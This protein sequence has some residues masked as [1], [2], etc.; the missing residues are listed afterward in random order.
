MAPELLMGGSLK[1]PSDI[2]S[3]G[4]TV[5]EVGNIICQGS[6]N[7]HDLRIR[8]IRATLRS[9]IVTLEKFASSFF[10]TMSDLIDRNST[11][12]HS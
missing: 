5:Y 6:S 1:K 12:L 11:K 10:S 8:S 9:D 2:Y 3:F 7:N 4:L